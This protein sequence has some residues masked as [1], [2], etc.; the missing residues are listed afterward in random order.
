MTMDLKTLRSEP[1]HRLRALRFTSQ[2]QL[3]RKSLFVKKQLVTLKY[4]MRM[5]SVCT[6]HRRQCKHLPLFDEPT[7]AIFDEHTFAMSVGYSAV[8]RGIDD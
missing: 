6:W 8:D 1:S 7:F 3:S 4:A 5:H 2:P